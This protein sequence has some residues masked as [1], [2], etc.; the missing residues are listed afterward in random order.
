[1]RTTTRRTF[2][3][4]AGACAALGPCAPALAQ[5]R[6]IRLGDTSALPIAW[7]IYIADKKGYFRE[8]GLAIESTYTNSNPAVA[9]QVVGGNFD[10]GVTTYET[11]V[12]AI[13]GQAPL[14]ITGSLMRAFPYVIMSSPDVKSPA[15]MRGKTVV[16]PLAKSILTVFWNRWLVENGL[17][18]DEVDQVYDAATPNRFAALKSRAAQAAVLSQPFDWMAAAD[19][20]TKLLDLGARVRDFGFTAFVARQDWTAKNPEAMKAFLRAVSRAVPFLY[21]PANREECADILAPPTK[22]DRANALRAWDYYATELKPFDKSLDLP[23]RQIELLV[24]TLIEM[25]DFRA[26]EDYRPSRFV[27]SS[28]LPG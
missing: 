22:M 8:E 12:R 20:F 16:L 19:G 21:D 17:K 18:P 5:T 28:F 26:G 9:Q 24:G 14:R 6:T 4:G 3:K 15:D 25:G 13:F 23:D 1:M 10:I 7:P 2:V 11:G 27:D